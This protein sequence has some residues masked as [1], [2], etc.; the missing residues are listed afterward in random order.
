LSDQA[1]LLARFS[2]NWAEALAGVVRSTGGRILRRAA[3]AA[4]DVGRPAGL[5]YSVVLLEPLQA[6][7]AATLLAALDT[8]FAFGPASKSGTVY[9]FTTWPVPDLTPCGW[10]LVEQMPLMLRLPGADTTPKPPD[11]RISEVQCARDLHHFEQV[12]IRGFPV[13]ELVGLPAGSAFGTS[14]LENERYR[15]WL[16]WHDEQLVCAS[17]AYVAHGL[18]D[19]VFLATLPRARGRGFGSALARIATLADPDL[20]AMLIASQEGQHLYTRMGYRHVC[21]MPLWIRERP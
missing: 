13:P 9:L 1:G 5:L 2:L 4:T 6:V 12:M 16:G 3:M 7:T 15:F 14:L 20:P 17:A 11:L 21:D 8:F 18:V 10:V 19:L